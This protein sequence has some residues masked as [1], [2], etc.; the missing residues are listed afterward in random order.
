MARLWLPQPVGERYEIKR[1][2]R[3]IGVFVPDWRTMDIS[4]FR[5]ILQWQEEKAAKPK[6][7]KP[8]PTMSR[9]QI[10]IGLRDYRDFQKA[11][12]EGRR[13]LY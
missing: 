6:P 10:I 12:R 9:E 7:P 8:A 11:R 13:R 4:Q 5:E 1:R 2:L 3:E